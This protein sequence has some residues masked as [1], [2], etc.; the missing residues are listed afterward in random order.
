M[1]IFY[2]SENAFMIIVDNRI[3]FKAIDKKL[4]L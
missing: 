4:N 3:E 2:M 1:V